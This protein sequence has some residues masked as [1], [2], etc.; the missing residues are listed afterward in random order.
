[1]SNVLNIKEGSE[2]GF[3]NFGDV[4]LRA[5]CLENVKYVV[6]MV[7]SVSLEVSR[8]SFSLSFDGTTKKPIRLAITVV[9]EPYEIDS[10]VIFVLSTE[11]CI[12]F[13]FD[14]KLDK[15]VYKLQ[16]EYETNFT[17]RIDRS[18]PLCTRTMTGS[19]ALVLRSVS[20][21]SRDTYFPL[22]L[23]EKRLF[24]FSPKTVIKAGIDYK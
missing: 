3:V 21:F 5:N 9:S 13:T 19:Q 22:R 2:I 11:E 6:R 14:L 4:L 1:M 20:R 17:I 18:L 10:R 24:L 8:T 23:I 7:I 12:T 15:A 16:A